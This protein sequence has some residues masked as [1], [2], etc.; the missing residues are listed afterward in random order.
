[1]TQSESLARLLEEFLADSPA[2]VVLEEGEELFD[3]ARA[4]YELRSE[5]GRCLLHLWSEERNLVRRVVEAEHKKDALVLTVQRFGQSKAVR[6]EI[7]RDRDRRSPSA[8]KASR[9]E[10]LRV[11][12][13]AL[14]RGFPGFTLSQLTTSMDLERSFGPAY[15]RGVLRRGRSAFAVL[16]VNQQEPRATVD[17]SLTFALLW[18]EH[19][20]QREAARAHVEGLKLIV[21]AG[22][23]AVVRER[24][25]HL[26]HAAAR[27][28]LYEF[29][30]HDLEI[31]QLDCRDRGN[32]ATRLVRWLNPQSSEERFAASIAR[33]RAAM[34]EAEVVT[35][36]SAEVAFRRHGLEFA[37]ARMEADGSFRPRAAITF[38]AGARETALNDATE[39]LFTELLQRLAAARRA[40]GERNHPLWRM[41]PE[42]WLESLVVRDVAA[43]DARLEA[44]QVY[45]QVPAFA[46]SDRAMI[47]VLT[48]TREG[49]LAVVELKADEDI[50]LVLQG[51]DYW[52][53]VVWHHARGEFQPF[54]YFPQREL[55]AAPP[56]LLLVAPALHVHPATD[57]LLRYLAPEIECT[58]LGLDERW[59]EGVRVV[60]R[61]RA[62]TP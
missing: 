6:L 53:R 20:R 5:H 40:A 30:E 56:L 46:A 44:S 26:D 17:A 2:A 21:P 19:C 7:A 10:Y 50:H 25:A 35:L 28:E 61:K 14:E 51:V 12:R 22:S 38:G 58:L 62:A 37:R 47:D 33:V 16:G 59:R 3:L 13:R 39:S 48:A 34:P 49:R 42:R 31:A 9:S 1:M 52:A 8:R 57:T 32:I 24:M 43:L 45:S 60:F 4:R 23:G 36:S 55:S 29:A 54:G 18:L 15:A 11:L 41:Q 27:F